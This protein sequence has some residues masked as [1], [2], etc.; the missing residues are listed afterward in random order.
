MNL[1]LKQRRAYSAGLA[2]ILLTALF[3]KRIK[4][5]AAKKLSAM[6]PCSG[7]TFPR[8]SRHQEQEKERFLMKKAVIK[9]LCLALL[10]VLGGCQKT[11]Y[12][13]SGDYGYDL[14]ESGN[15]VIRAYN[16]SETIL[17]LPAQLDGHPITGIGGYSFRDIRVSSVVSLEIPEGYT[18]II[19]S[20]FQ[21]CLQ[22]ESVKLSSTLKYIGGYAFSGTQSLRHLKLPEGLTTLGDLAFCDSALESINIPDT[23]TE[24]RDN[25]FAGCKQLREIIISDQQPALR[26]TGGV[27]TNRDGTVLLVYPASRTDTQYSVPEEILDIAPYAFAGSPLRAVT[28]P[29]KLKVIENGLFEGCETLGDVAIPSGVE[30]IGGEAFSGCTEL[31]TAVLPASVTSFGDRVFA[32]CEKLTLVVA[33]GSAAERYAKENK[34]PYRYSEPEAKA[35]E[36]PAGTPVPSSAAS[37]NQTQMPLAALELPTFTAKDFSW[38]APATGE[39]LYIGEAEVS[40]AK[41]MYLAFIVSA[42]G[43]RI[44]DLIIHSENVDIQYNDNGA[45]V[46]VTAGSITERAKGVLSVNRGATDVHL[47]ETWINQLVIAGD[48]ASCTLA[49]VYR[50]TDSDT[51]SPV[52]LPFDVATITLQNYSITATPAAK[53]AIQPPSA[54]EVKARGFDLPIP[55]AG[56]SLY[57]G[58]ADVSQ[59][60]QLYVAFIVSSDGTG[61]HDLTIFIADLAVRIESGNTVTQVKGGSVTE[62][63]GGAYGTGAEA[64]AINLG[65]TQITDLTITGDTASC[66]LAYVY[67][68]S[69]GIGSGSSSADVPFDIATVAFK[70]Q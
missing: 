23:V 30:E 18:E 67:H 34:L 24:F 11:G 14:Y 42:D 7:L 29:E 58:A 13:V 62:R 64:F 39:R 54:A 32:G 63:Y 51:G 43:D 3:H 17:T 15:A 69:G 46:R 27:L 19:S 59:A 53:P 20:A 8:Q 10:A 41:R 35:E 45:A 12:F 65:R 25:P 33:P 44:H 2:L 61:L 49:Y 66:I 50:Y 52:S 60:N 9:A 1:S 22:L 26:W 5:G 37:A 57:I 21:N 48:T 40:Q 56:E 55:A 68:Y 6:K 70:R 28:L 4:D 36:A 38:P 31:E 16:G 47:G